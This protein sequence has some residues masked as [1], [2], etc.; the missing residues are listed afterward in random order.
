MLAVMTGRDHLSKREYV[1]S[2]GA[3]LDQAATRLDGPG[4]G[5]VSGKATVFDKSRLK[6]EQGYLADAGR[7]QVT[8]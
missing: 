4:K 2:T 3:L 1:C 8:Q 5:N 7:P 6:A